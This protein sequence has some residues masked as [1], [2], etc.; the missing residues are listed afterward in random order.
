MKLLWLALFSVATA[1]F[2]QSP[3]PGKIDPDKLFQLPD[4]FTH[5]APDFNAFKSLPP[6]K[7][8]FIFVNPTIDLPRPRLDNP[9][10]DPKIILRPPWRNRSKGQDVGSNL[11]PHLKLLPIRRPGP[12]R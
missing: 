12:A 1:A 6:M 4:K 10:I 3:A 11:Y 5:A 2:C 7:N 8:E 9:Q